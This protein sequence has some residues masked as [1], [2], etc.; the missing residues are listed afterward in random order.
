MSHKLLVFISKF[1]RLKNVSHL[2]V[3]PN[4]AIL[5]DTVQIPVQSLFCRAAWV[6]MLQLTHIQGVIRFVACVLSLFSL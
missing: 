3:A 4:I 2:K 5:S 6:A 1:I